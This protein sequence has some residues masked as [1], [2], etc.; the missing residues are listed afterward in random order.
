[1]RRATGAHVVFGMNLEEPDIRLS[2][3]DF[4]IMLGLE[5]EACARRQVA[6]VW[7]DDHPDVLFEKTGRPGL[8]VTAL[9]RPWA[10]AT[11]YD[12]QLPW[13]CRCRQ[14]PPSRHYPG[15]P[16]SMCPRKS[17]PDRRRNH[18]GP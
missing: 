16:W 9:R 13:W 8:P 14:A 6:A 17:C 5:A 10:G 4:P 15:N 11:P 7:H 18:S 2:I 1:M 3:E 12:R